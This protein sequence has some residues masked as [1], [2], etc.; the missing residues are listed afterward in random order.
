MAGK[1]QYCPEAN[2]LQGTISASPV[3]ATDYPVTWL[4]DRWHPLRA[5]R[6]TSLA[7]Q[8]IDIDLGVNKTI[9]AI[10]LEHFNV[11]QLELKYGTVTP[12]TTHFTGSPF[13]TPTALKKDRDGIR[14][15]IVVQTV[16]ARYLR[17]GI[18]THTPASGESY[19]FLG[20]IFVA[21]AWSTMVNNPDDPIGYQL[22]GAYQR[23]RKNNRHEKVRTGNNVMRITWKGSALSVAGNDEWE[24]LELLGEETP[25]LLYNNEDKAEEMY[26]VRSEEPS[27]MSD[28]ITHKQRTQI[29]ETLA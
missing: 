12:P 26:W 20:T 8:T 21:G 25:V 29:W 27:E 2:M 7:T 1:I 6:S 14:K 11:D 18:P 22:L 9:Y 10:A 24:T 23:N 16:T 13:T 3:M 15:L 5:L 4:Q 19:F 28:Y 17:I